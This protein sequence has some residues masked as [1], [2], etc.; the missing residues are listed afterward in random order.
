MISF[1]IISAHISVYYL[2]LENRKSRKRSKK[3]SKQETIWEVL[4][5]PGKIKEQMAGFNPKKL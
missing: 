3:I 2:W 1:Q 5:E 4:S